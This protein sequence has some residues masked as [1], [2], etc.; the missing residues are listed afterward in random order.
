MDRVHKL[1]FEQSHHLSRG[2]I[3][4]SGS[5]PGVCFGRDS[6]LVVDV[7]EYVHDPVHEYTPGK[8]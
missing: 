3:D 7:I 2:G 8:K 5:S 4:I 1:I 6:N